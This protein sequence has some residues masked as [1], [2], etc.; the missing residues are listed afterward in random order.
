MFAFNFNFG[1]LLKIFGLKWIKR[2][3]LI[4]EL[5]SLYKILTLIVR[6]FL[7]QLEQKKF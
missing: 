1:I 6:T 7:G 2:P 5:I 3:K 4:F